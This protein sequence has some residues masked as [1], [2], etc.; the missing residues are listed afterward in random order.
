MTPET[1]DRFKAIGPVLTP[2][3]INITQSMLA[4]SFQGLDPAT[5]IER[6]ISYGPHE[7]HE[8][9]IFTR[10]GT[11]GAPVLVFVHGGGFVM[12]DKRSAATPFYENVGNFAAR[13]GWVGVTIN[14][15]LAPDHRWPSG[16][17]DLARVVEWLQAHIA[18]YGGDPARIFV[19]G[20]SAGAVHVAEY[21]ARYAPKVAGA[22]LISGIYDVSTATPNQFQAAYYGDDR[23]AY[24]A[25]A[26]L[27]GLVETKVPLL[28][29]TAEFDPHD[30]Q[31]QAA[32]LAA[33]Y[34]AHHQLMPWF[35]FLAGHNHLSPV[36]EIGSPDAMLERHIRDFIAAH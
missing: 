35:H 18:E 4:T 30:F 6:D 12:G 17:E 11:S 5:R 1:R 33:A 27:P 32:N 19:M 3:M 16:G 28:I 21:I 24:P 20:Q 29:V 15:R 26:T 9:D 14:Y 8:L 36:L 2:D 34:T 7:R 25:T 31:V 10:E 23:S 13:Q 22:L